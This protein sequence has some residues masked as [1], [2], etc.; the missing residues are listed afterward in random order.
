MTREY[1]QDPTCLKAAAWFK[2][3]VE[4]NQALFE[5][6]KYSPESMAQSQTASPV[7]SYR[8]VI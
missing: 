4:L 5:I 2:Q 1:Q 8:D 6:G 3:C 7:L